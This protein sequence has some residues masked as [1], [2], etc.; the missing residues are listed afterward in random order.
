MFS[1][2]IFFL[3]LSITESWKKSYINFFRTS[4]VFVEFISTDC[5]IIIS[6]RSLISFNAIEFLFIHHSL[7]RVPGKCESYFYSDCFVKKPQFISFFKGIFIRIDFYN[8]SICCKVRWTVFGALAS[9]LKIS[10]C[11]GIVPLRYLR[12]YHK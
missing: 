9:G 7:N 4:Y 10:V 8:C 12:N 5:I 3:D 6:L 1:S 2:L 11:Y